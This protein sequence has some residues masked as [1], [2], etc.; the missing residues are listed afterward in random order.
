MLVDV[1]GHDAEDEFAARDLEDAIKR[2]APPI[3]ILPRR[4]R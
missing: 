1:P 4:F 3:S 2:I